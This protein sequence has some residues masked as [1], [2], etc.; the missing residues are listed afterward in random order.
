[1]E[2]G[3]NLSP[4][5]MAV[6]KRCARKN[7]GTRISTLHH[8]TES[9]RNW[10]TPHCTFDDDDEITNLTESMANNL[11]DECNEDE[12]EMGIEKLFQTLMK[13]KHHKTRGE[14][15]CDMLIKKIVLY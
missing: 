12:I 3:P 7:R 6:E 4:H 14:F 9:L 5:L 13:G 11:N 15:T 2:N 1:M 10:K 8:P